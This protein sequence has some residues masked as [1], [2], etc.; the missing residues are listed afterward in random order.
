[1]DVGARADVHRLLRAAA[2]RGAAVVVASSDVDELLALCHR[3]LVLA[4]GRVAATFARGAFS[5]E[6]I[7][8][9]AVGAAAATRTA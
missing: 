3:V 8:D 5:R 9:A 7:L 1:V 6:Q 4:R 2:Q